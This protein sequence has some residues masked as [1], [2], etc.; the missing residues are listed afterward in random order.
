MAV[1]ISLMVG[2]IGCVIGANVA[3]LL[4]ERYCETVFYLFGS[5]MLGE[6]EFI[7]LEIINQLSYHI[8]FFPQQ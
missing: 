3:A 5:M 7:I 8:C 4:L 2:R 6:T 1:C